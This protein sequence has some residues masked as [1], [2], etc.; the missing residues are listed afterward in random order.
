MRHP[1]NDKVSTAEYTVLV[2]VSIALLCAV[3]LHWFDPKQFKILVS[4]DGWL[5]WST[6]VVLTGL[7]ILCLAKSYRLLTSRNLFGAAV[8]LGYAAVFIFGAGEEV[9]W[10]QRIF[11][12][13]E[14]PTY[15]QENNLQKEL[16]FHNLKIGGV[17]VNKLLFG[18]ILTV[19]ITF[20]LL[21]LRLIYK[22]NRTFSNFVK[23][24][25]IPLP[26]YTH[27]I[28]ALVWVIIIELSGSPKKGELFEV[29]LPILVLLIFLS[30]WNRRNS[31]LS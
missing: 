27:T 29:A 25:H 21:F 4:E 11:G 12:M 10:G 8:L 18:K 1:Y 15:F 5:E 2:M 7:A 20:Y 14:I 23:N 30:S 3:A 6:V 24:F 22:Y 26:K 28:F 19:C 13:N 16:N 31:V 17:G 9:S